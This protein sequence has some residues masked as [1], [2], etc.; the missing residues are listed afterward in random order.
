MRASVRKYTGFLGLDEEEPLFIISL[1]SM[2]PP[3]LEDTEVIQRIINKDKDALYLLYDKYSGALFGV[4][5]RIC[6]N[7]VLAEDVLQETFVKIWEKMGSYNPDKGRFYTWAYRIAKNTAL[8]AVRKS[9]KLIQN[10]DLGVLKD[11]S[12]TESEVDLQKL[13]GAISRLEPHHQEAISLVYFRGYTHRE[14][15]EEMGVPLGTF[16][17]YIRQALQLLRESYK[18]GIVLFWWVTE[19]IG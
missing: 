13:N 5:L 3:P 2:E 15:N 10:E 12:T 8:N 11:K 17:S 6:Q 7:Q 19:V 18:I 1:T 16:K 4:I 9:D 14:A